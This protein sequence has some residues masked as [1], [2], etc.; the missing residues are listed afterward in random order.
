M[1][2]PDPASVTSKAELRRFATRLLGQWIAKLDRDKVVLHLPRRRGLMRLLP[3][4]H[5]H[6]WPELFLQVSGSTIFQFPEESCRVG[7]GEICLVSRGLPHREK[8]LPK[9]GPFFNLVISYSP[10]HI[11][12][13][14]AR[15]NAAGHPFIAI[16]NAVPTIKSVHLADLLNDAADWFHEGDAARRFAVKGSLLANLSIVLASIKEESVDAHEPLKVMQ[17]RQLI[18]QSLSR[19]ELSV[20]WIGQSLQS[21]P[22]YLSQLFRGTMGKSLIGYITERKVNRARDLLES[23]TLNISE[24]SRAC[25]YDDPSYF[26]RIFRKETGFPPRQ[27]RDHVVKHSE[28]AVLKVAARF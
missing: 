20:S 22:E 11:H 23:S 10:G 14:I 26:T 17:A 21:S 13:H 6:L 16:A 7:P 1:P 5:F 2:F 9:R 8:A 18:E 27:Y 28:D 3:D 4:M 15:Q 19:S 12:F 24:I 25:G